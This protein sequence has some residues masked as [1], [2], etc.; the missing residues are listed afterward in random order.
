MEIDEKFMRRALQ[1]ARGGMGH[2]SPNPMVG[3]VIVR[4]GRIIGEGYH[5]RY[6]EG[7]AEVNAVASVADK[8]LL[9][10]CTMYVTLEPCSHYGK[11]PP[12][13]KLIID[14][15]I[16]RVAVGCI[17]PTGKV[18]GKGV[19]MLREAGVEVVTGVLERECLE[20]NE[21]FITSHL[22]ERPW[23]TLK[24]AM[25]ADGFLDS[26]RVATGGKPERFSS[27]AS[28][29]LVHLMRSRHDAIMAGSGTV[30]AD[31]PRLDVRGVE[32]CSPVKVLVDRRGRIPAE[33]SALKGGRVLHFGPQRTDL[34]DGVEIMRCD[35]A[36]PLREILDEL[37]RQKV[38]S[39][40]VEGG[41]ALLDSFIAE[42]LWNECRIE[43][44]GRVL[45]ESGRCRMAVPEGVMSSVKAIGGNTVINVKNTPSV[46]IKR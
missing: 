34:P 33:A 9:H 22:T 10:D 17:D 21:V 46:D 16:P 23:V 36:T 12:C 42:G 2:V 25:S 6:G 39:L 45:G 19:A 3:A 14:S 24:W 11:T 37:Y 30:M 26:D 7:H 4:D 35:E 29:R 27:P 41:K 40:L 38:T 1:I 8:S 28:G 44:S 31:N 20:L 18:D 15:G 43:V 5:R 32:G 13:A